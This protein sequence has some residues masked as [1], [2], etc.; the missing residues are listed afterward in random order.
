MTTK[1]DLSLLLQ[2]TAWA[3]QPK[4]LDVIADVLWLHKNNRSALNEV[5]ASTGDVEDKRSKTSYEVRDGVAIIPVVG[6]IAKQTIIN[7]QVIDITRD[8][9]SATIMASKLNISDKT[10]TSRLEFISSPG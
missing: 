1:I 2:Q 4:A 9:A 7:I 6:T 5:I 3:I 8:A 10:P